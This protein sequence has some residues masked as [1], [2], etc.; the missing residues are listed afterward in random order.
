MN[1]YIN[2]IPRSTSDLG[3]AKNKI[4]QACNTFWN[5][6]THPCYTPQLYTNVLEK[7][8]SNSKIFN[9]STNSGVFFNE[10]NAK[11][12]KD[13]NLHLVLFQYSQGCGSEF[14][15]SILSDFITKYKLQDNVSLSHTDVLDYNVDCEVCKNSM[16]D[17]VLFM[18]VYPLCNKDRMFNMLAHISKNILKDS[19]EVIFVHNMCS[20]PNVVV[21]LLKP[22]IKYVPGIWTDY[23]ELVSIKDFNDFVDISYFYIESSNVIASDTILNVIDAKLNIHKTIIEYLRG[24][25]DMMYVIDTHK[26]TLKKNQICD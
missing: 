3:L 25:D 13:K 12:I 14:E 21:K 2:H 1:T 7:C 5:S 4:T 6:S 10:A 17:V 18:E 8:E 22:Y 9:V 16:F 23:G 26:V 19:G 20:D 15:L 11:I 24:Y